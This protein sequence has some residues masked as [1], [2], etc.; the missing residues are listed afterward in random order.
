MQPQ[1]TRPEWFQTVPFVRAIDPEF[2]IA[3]YFDDP[4]VDDDSKDY[5]A[6]IVKLSSKIRALSKSGVILAS[7]KITEY[8]ETIND[9]FQY[10]LFYETRDDVEMNDKIDEIDDNGC[11]AF[12]ERLGIYK[13]F[14]IFENIEGGH[15]LVSQSDGPCFETRDG[16]NRFC[17][18]PSHDRESVAIADAQ[19]FI[20]SFVLSRRNDVP[21]YDW[22]MLGRL[23]LSL[24][25]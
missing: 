6:K 7:S 18:I 10:P 20:D 15:I 25:L 2:D 12:W 19:E 17:E 24:P 1:T 21:E 13:G 8:E 22:N 3:E 11:G 23:Q 14:Q 5:I 9:L 4:E 16:W